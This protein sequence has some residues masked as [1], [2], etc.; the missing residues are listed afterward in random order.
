MNHI[1]Q[2]LAIALGLTVAGMAQARERDAYYAYGEVVRVDPVIV[3]NEQPVHR[4][5]CRDVPVE[6]YQPGYT[7]HRDR[8]GSTIA[9]AIVGGALGSLVGRGD[10]RRAATVAG[11]LIGGSIAHD[12]AR[13]GYYTTGGYYERGYQQRCRT[14]T[15][16]ENDDQVTGYDV[17]YRYHGETYQERL[18]YD[19][20]NRVRISVDGDDV[21]IVD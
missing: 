11:A 8:T 13:S 5:V 4:E 12:H 18:D 6:Y 15:E 9:G 1:K 19:P 10:G 17:T 20:G 7:Y 3:S 16:Y 2:I 21:Q 14:E